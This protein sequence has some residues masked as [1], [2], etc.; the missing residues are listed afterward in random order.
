M[1][2]INKSEHK[3]FEDYNELPIGSAK[4]CEICRKTPFILYYQ[5]RDIF[6]IN[7]CHNCKIE[8]WK[9]KS[10]WNKIKKWLYRP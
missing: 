1:N 8:D 5:S 2:T 3:Y 7:R 9:P 6:N 4:K 10:L